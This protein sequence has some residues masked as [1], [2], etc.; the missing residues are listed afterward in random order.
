M[1]GSLDR[2]TLIELLDEL[3]KR[4]E[5]RRVRAQVYVIGGAAMSLAFDRARTTHDIDARIDSGHGALTEAVRE[6]AR[7][8]GLTGAWLNEQ[9]TANIPRAPDTRAQTVYESAYLTITGAS[10]EHILAM[11]LEAGR[12]T[13][14]GDVAILIGHLGITTAE[15]ALA[16]HGRL[17]PESTRGSQAREIVEHVLTDG[18]GGKK[19]LLPAESS[20]G[21]A[22]DRHLAGP[23]RSRQV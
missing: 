20:F 3:S 11:K 1:R 12:R 23:R 19:R 13:D 8:R 22:R 21:A 5:R 16:I 10:A 7:E 6:I 17:F 14:I 9:A 2:E 4:L 18:D 15:E